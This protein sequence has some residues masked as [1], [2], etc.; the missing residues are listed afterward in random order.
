M[1]MKSE[2]IIHGRKCC[3]YQSGEANTFLIQA[4]GKHESETLDR[5]FEIIKELS[6][7]KPFTL[8]AFFVDDWNGELSPWNSPAVFGREDFGSGA[9]KTLSFITEHLLP[10]LERLYAT[11]EKKRCFIGGYSLSGLFSLWAAYQ[12]DIFSGVAAVSPSV[13]FPGWI[14]YVETHP[15]QTHSVYLSLGDKEEK[16]RNKTMAA[17]GKNIRR[18]YDLLINTEA[19][20]KCELEWNAGSHFAEPERRTAK[21]FAWL[22]NASP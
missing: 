15:I 10:E 6:H 13:W 20:S 4:V 7:G 2:L 3:I 11:A 21:G 12:T 16:T 19:I 22:L 9:G 8:A 14:Q 17:V 1:Y 18:E 5:E